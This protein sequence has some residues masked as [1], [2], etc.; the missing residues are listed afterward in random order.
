MGIFLLFITEGNERE[1]T[2]SHFNDTWR[3]SL[4]GLRAFLKKLDS[5]CQEECSQDKQL[6]I[7]CAHFNLWNQRH[8]D[9][10]GYRFNNSKDTFWHQC[11][12]LTI[13]VKIAILITLSRLQ[14]LKYYA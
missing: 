10:Y 13:M 11:S 7:V 6:E 12:F 2:N 1:D 4:D 14:P 3:T 9:G 8:P 5:E